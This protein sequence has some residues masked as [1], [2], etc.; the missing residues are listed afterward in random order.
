MMNRVGNNLYFGVMFWIMVKRWSGYTGAGI[1]YLDFW[2]W[3]LRIAFDKMRM[4]VLPYCLMWL[5]IF[6]VDSM[7]LHISAPES[8]IHQ[9]SPPASLFDATPPSAPD[10]TPPNNL[11]L[12]PPNLDDNETVVDLDAQTWPA[13]VEELEA[14]EDVAAGNAVSKDAA[15]SFWMTTMKPSFLEEMKDLDLRRCLV[16]CLSGF[17]MDL[18]GSIELECSS[19]LR[20]PL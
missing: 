14:G 18:N 10:S 2:S 9:T 20:D 6:R 3:G 15:T 11:A 4:H 17:I 1:E 12:D 13:P 5:A 8:D 7:N 19:S 16:T